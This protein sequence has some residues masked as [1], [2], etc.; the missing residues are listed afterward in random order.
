MRTNQKACITELIIEY[1]FNEGYSLKIGLYN[2]LPW[3]F[4]SQLIIC[5]ELAFNENYLTSVRIE[6]LQIVYALST[7]QNGGQI[8]DKAY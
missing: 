8:R 1:K 6:T 7:R 5:L 3:T 2:P 4:S